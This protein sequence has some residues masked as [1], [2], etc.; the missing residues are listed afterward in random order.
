MGREDLGA[1]RFLTLGLERLV[2]SVSSD[3]DTEVRADYGPD[4]SNHGRRE[5]GELTGG[6][7]GAVGDKQHPHERQQP[8]YERQQTTDHL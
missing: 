1:R 2:G 4:N 8:G 7:A 6:H 3:L 5:L